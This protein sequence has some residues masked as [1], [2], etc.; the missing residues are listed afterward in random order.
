[1]LGINRQRLFA[2]MRK[3][4]IQCV[5]DPSS[6][7]IAFL[8]PLLL[9]FI[10]GY[11]MSLDA[12]KIRIG[13]VLE[14]NG[15]QG[16]SLAQAFMG[17]PYFDITF[18]HSRQEIE[19]AIS[20]AQL[21]GMVVIPEDFS[22]KLQSGQIAPVQIV[23]DG[24]ETNTA[25]F[26]E[27]Y[28]YGVIG[29]WQNQQL[30]EQ[31]LMFPAQII[32]QNRAWYNPELKSRNVLLPG[33]IP[34]TMSLIGTL[35][36]A[37]VIAREW[38]HGTMEAILST[39][40]R[41]SEM[42]LGKLTPYFLLGLGSMTLCVI[43]TVFWFDVPFR[44]SFLALLLGTSAFLLAA[45]GQGLLISTL[46]HTQLVA[47]QVAIMIGF[48]P[49][50]VLSGFLFEIDSMPEWIQLFTYLLPP[51]Y[52]VPILQSVFLVGDVWQLIIPNVLYL[53]IIA[54]VFFLLTSRK[55]VKRLD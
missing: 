42:L 39:P 15:Q 52:F 43:I 2:F 14:D 54:S 36:T 29:N 28:A 6:I 40:I 26:V 19:N 1:M 25:T 48:L 17:T 50:F 30:V 37:L 4:V 46:A 8:L 18:S 49:S 16:Y 22:Q 47:S 27:N 32:I 12:N 44:G 21:R 24:G 33:S 13:L 7:L 53:L 51:R 45:L 55:T 34:I 5:R 35:L 38:E 10:F 23:A 31:D 41:I 9:M 11:G 20:N 3:E